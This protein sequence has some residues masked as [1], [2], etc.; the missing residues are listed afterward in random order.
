MYSGF[1]KETLKLLSTWTAKFQDYV[2]TTQ[3]MNKITSM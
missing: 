3:N 1:Y 2:E